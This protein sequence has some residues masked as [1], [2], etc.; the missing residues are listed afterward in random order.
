LGSGAH[1]KNKNPL[2][3]DNRRDSS[4]N[5]LAIVAIT[6]MAL[7]GSAAG[8]SAAD[9][10]A[11]TGTASASGT[12]KRPLLLVDGKRYELK[13]ADKADLSVAEALT[14]FSKGDTGTYTVKGVRGTVN[15]GIIVDS[16]A[17]A[18]KPAAVPTTPTVTSSVVTVGNRKY[19]V[20]DYADPRGTETTKGFIR[21]SLMVPRC[22]R[23]VSE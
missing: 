6:L 8:V 12:H 16:I 18:A 5:R 21:Q 9:R 11:F 20:Y 14:K 7:A 17:P 10:E 1:N 13:A 19:T 22:S 4:M 23:V 3:N 2:N 15:D